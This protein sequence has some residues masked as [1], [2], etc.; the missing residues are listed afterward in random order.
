[1]WFQHITDLQQPLTEEESQIIDSLYESHFSDYRN[2]LKV[3]A[4]DQAFILNEME[5]IHQGVTPGIFKGR[6]DLDRV[7]AFGE[8]F[9]GATAALFS[10]TDPRCRASANYDGPQ[11]GTLP[12][13]SWKKPHLMI[14]DNDGWEQDWLDQDWAYHGNASPYYRMSNQGATHSGGNFLFDFPLAQWLGKHGN[15]T[16]STKR[17]QEI[18]SAYLVAF[19]NQFLKGASQD[20]LKGES[21]YMEVKLKKYK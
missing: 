13:P 3:W 12:T 4:A 15:M 14:F 5:K 8:S 20:L 17:F 2:R 10:A 18:K 19:F 7:G 9:G 1:M 11:F 16:I 21:P 6:L